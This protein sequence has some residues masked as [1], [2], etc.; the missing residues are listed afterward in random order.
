MSTG[1]LRHY[2]SGI[3]DLIAATY[4]ATSDRMEAIFAAAVEDAGSDPRARLAA[5]LT[6]TFRPPVTEPEML[7]AWT[8]FW[9]LARS[10]ARKRRNPAERSEGSAERLW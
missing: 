7:G 10:D 3:N 2:F 9:A 4:R 8:P 1:L 6:A 5:Y